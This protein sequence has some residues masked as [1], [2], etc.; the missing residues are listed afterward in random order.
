MVWEFRL[1]VSYVKEREELIFKT[2]RIFIVWV[3]SNLIQYNDY[4]RMGRFGY[5]FKFENISL[6]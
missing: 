4:S 5:F 3:F 2:N 1:L 6:F